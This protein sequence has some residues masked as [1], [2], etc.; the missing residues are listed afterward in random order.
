MHLPIDCSFKGRNHGDHY[1][2]F[3]NATTASIPHSCAASKTR[4]WT[5]LPGKKAGD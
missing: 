3:M 5:S 4:H 1:L 2:L